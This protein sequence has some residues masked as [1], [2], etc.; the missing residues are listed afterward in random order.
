MKLLVNEPV[1]NK[2]LKGIT[3]ED[4]TAKDFRTY[5]GTRIAYDVIG[6]RA[7]PKLDRT[8]IKSA[9]RNAINSGAITSE[10][11]FREF[12]FMHAFKQQ[13]ALK[14]DI[15]GEPVSK[16]L[17]NKPKVSIDNYINPLIF[18]DNPNNKNWDAAFKKETASLLRMVYPKADVKVAQDWLAAVA[19]IDYA[20]KGLKKPRR[21]K[22]WKKGD[23]VPDS[24]GPVKPKEGKK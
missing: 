13:G 23:K 3:G 22:D 11:L 15:V 10:Q 2:Y 21:P 19:K 8:K 24:P 1:V 7:I 4:L 6:K 9:L 16:R 5:H 18:S 17:G 12:T 20:A 14:R